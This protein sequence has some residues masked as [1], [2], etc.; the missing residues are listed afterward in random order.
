MWRASDCQD[1]AT[2]IHA[3]CDP[4]FEGLEIDWQNSK[5]LAVTGKSQNIFLWDITTPL[6]P[7]KV[8]M[9]GHS[10]EVEQIK[11]DPSG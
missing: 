1:V 10:S 7:Q 9:G 4:N 8:W 5:S 3:Q 6:L 11:W 2:L